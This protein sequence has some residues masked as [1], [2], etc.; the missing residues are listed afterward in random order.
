MCRKSKIQIITYA[1]LNMYIVNI[2]TNKITKRD[3][4]TAKHETDNNSH[5]INLYREW[6]NFF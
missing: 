4:H 6:T 1:F 5:K 3:R 2:R